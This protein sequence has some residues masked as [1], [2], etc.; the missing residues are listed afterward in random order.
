VSLLGAVFRLVWGAE[1]DRALR[2]ILAVQLAGSLAGGCA[3][4]FL[5][6]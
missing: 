6:I 5:G 2:P 3:F 1:V 4:P